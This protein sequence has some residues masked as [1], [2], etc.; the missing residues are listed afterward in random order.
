MSRNVACTE[1]DWTVHASCELRHEDLHKQSVRTQ[2]FYCGTLNLAT[3]RRLLTLAAI[4]SL[5]G[6]AILFFT[7]HPC[8]MILNLCTLDFSLK[9]AYNIQSFRCARR[10]FK[11]SPRAKV[12]PRVAGVTS[13]LYTCVMCH[14]VTTA[15][16]YTSGGPLSLSKTVFC[17]NSSSHRVA[18]IVHYADPSQSPT[19]TSGKDSSRRCS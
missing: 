7:S 15:S 4:W 16:A 8:G 9:Q 19:S 10:R 6:I 5:S 14:C 12:T 13:S 17:T 3:L 11:I 1:S 18:P 2:I